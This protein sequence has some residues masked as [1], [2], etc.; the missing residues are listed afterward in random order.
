MN[1]PQTERRRAALLAI[2]SEGKVKSQGEL[3]EKLEAQGFAVS[4]PVVSRDLRKLRVAKRGGTY[5]LLDDERVTPLTSLKSLLRGEAA[6]PHLALVRCEPGAANAVA[7]ALEAEDIDGVL[8]TIAG[9]DTVLV[10]VA[11]AGVAR[12]VRRT[13]ADLLES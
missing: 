5:Q 1:D 4:Q 9:D 13:V 7:R 2:L 8:G 6:V 11:T 3:I 12:R 10:I